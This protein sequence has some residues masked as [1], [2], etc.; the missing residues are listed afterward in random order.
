MKDRILLNFGL[1]SPLVNADTNSLTSDFW[2]FLSN[3]VSNINNIRILE[4]VTTNQALYVANW[5]TDLI[6]CDTSLNAVTIQMPA[7]SLI[8]YKPITIKCLNNANNVTILPNAL[9]TIDNASSIV[10]T[11]YESLQLISDGN[12]LWSI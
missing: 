11:A 10:L 2:R 8:K 5:N 12:N 9:E 4:T 6:L 3:I 7:A 1:K